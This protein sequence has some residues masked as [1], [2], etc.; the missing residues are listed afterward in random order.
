MLITLRKVL[1]YKKHFFKPLQW[2]IIPSGGLQWSQNL[3]TNFRDSTMFQ[4]QDI[5]ENGKPNIVL[6]TVKSFDL[7]RT[8]VVILILK[9][10]KIGNCCPR[11]V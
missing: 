2:K 4:I 9:K 8:P 7:K 10:F 6:K 11:H 5:F 1:N 3:T